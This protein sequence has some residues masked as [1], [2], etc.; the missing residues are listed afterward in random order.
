MTEIQDSLWQAATIMLTG[1]VVVFIFLTSLIFLVKLLAKVA[2]EESTVNVSTDV[3]SS[4][5]VNEGALSP[6]LVAVISSAVV[7]YRQRH[8]K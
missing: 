8:L 6:T 5:S 4:P 1:M 7:Q 2:G 3:I